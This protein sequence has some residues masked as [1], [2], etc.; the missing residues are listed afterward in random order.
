MVEAIPEQ[1]L[2]QTAPVTRRAVGVF[3]ESAII[4]HSLKAQAVPW[5]QSEVALGPKEVEGCVF[6]KTFTSEGRAYSSSFL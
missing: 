1:R 2:C 3:E 6:K 5:G 4:V